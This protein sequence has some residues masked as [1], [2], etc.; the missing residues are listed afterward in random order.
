MIFSLL[1]PGETYIPRLIAQAFNPNRA[2]SSSID[3]EF[4]S[5]LST[6]SRNVLSCFLASGRTLSIPGTEGSPSAAVMSWQCEGSSR[7]KLVS[8]PAASKRRQ[9]FLGPPHVVNLAL[10]HK[11]REWQ[12]R[13]LAARIF[14]IECIAYETTGD[15]NSCHAPCFESSE[16]GIR[17]GAESGMRRLQR[18]DV[19]LERSDISIAFVL[20]VFEAPQVIV[21]G[22]A[23]SSRLFRGGRGGACRVREVGGEGVVKIHDDSIIETCTVMCSIDRSQ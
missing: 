5:I 4:V 3:T 18:R 2:R 7:A 8:S 19:A 12:G 1:T 20:S 11:H 9:R 21:I 10:H 22:R 15:L 14:G 13:W 6:E 17:E 16:L 23:S